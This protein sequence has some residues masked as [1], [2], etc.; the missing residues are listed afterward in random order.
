MNT[1]VSERGV[2]EKKPSRKGSEGSIVRRWSF[3]KEFHSPCSTFCPQFPPE[4]DIFDSVLRGE[5]CIF[6]SQVPSNATNMLSNHAV[7][8][9]HL[10]HD[11]WNFFFL[12]NSLACS[13]AF[14]APVRSSSSA[15]LYSPSFNLNICALLL[16]FCDYSRQWSID[17]LAGA[18]GFVCMCE[19]EG[20][21]QCGP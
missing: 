20:R 16:L 18:F 6:T 13:L 8:Q 15:T 11:N 14:P 12:P 3:G 10:T 7:S 21:E 17:T 5:M 1:R 2:G 19:R 4:F 9:H